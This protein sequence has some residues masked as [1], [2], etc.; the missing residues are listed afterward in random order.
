MKMHTLYLVFGVL[1]VIYSVVWFL[2]YRYLKTDRPDEFGPV[3]STPI[4]I[5][6]LEQRA[7]GES[8]FIFSG[9]RRLVIT[10]VGFFALVIFGYAVLAVAFMILSHS[11]AT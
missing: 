11:A 1:S 6:T 3:D 7:R 5:T 10:G 9:G 2:A 4:E 8:S